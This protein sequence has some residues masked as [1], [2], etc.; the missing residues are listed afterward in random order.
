MSHLACDKGGFSPSVRE[1]NSE[2][3]GELLTSGLGL[4]QVGAVLGYQAMVILRAWTLYY[5][6]EGPPRQ[7][8]MG[9]G[10]S[11]L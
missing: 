3:R 7:A 11:L 4:A 2:A 9:I 5:W 8:T 1:Q 10:L 6:S